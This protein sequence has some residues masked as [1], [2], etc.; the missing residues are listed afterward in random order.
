MRILSDL[1]AAILPPSPGLALL[2]VCGRNSGASSPE[3]PLQAD[4]G[5]AAP[6]AF[7]QGQPHIFD[8]VVSPNNH[9]WPQA[10]HSL[11]S[12]AALGSF[13]VAMMV[14]NPPAMRETW[15]PSLGGEDPLQK[16]VTTP[17]SVLAWRIPW[18]EEPGRLQS[19]G[20]ERVRHD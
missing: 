18:A 10:I 1:E 5:I 13:L 7:R 14:K 2:R 20:S 19:T 15:V 11:C 17:S 12:L 16:G 8:Q 4:R 3:R 6:Q 9:I